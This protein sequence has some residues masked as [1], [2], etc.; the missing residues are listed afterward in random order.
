MKKP[1]TEVVAGTSAK[2]E[3]PALQQTRPPKPGGLKDERW[4]RIADQT[5]G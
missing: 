5:N 3:F 4:M 2:D 1:F